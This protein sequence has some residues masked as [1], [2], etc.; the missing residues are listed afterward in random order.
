M[1]L[2]IK[3]ITA[4]ILTRPGGVENGCCLRYHTKYWTNI[5]MGIFFIVNNMSGA[6][7]HAKLVCGH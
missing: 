2:H 5:E 3:I 6:K 7:A 1:F 4:R